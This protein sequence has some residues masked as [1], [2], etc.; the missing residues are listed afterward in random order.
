MNFMQDLSKSISTNGS[1]VKIY[2]DDIEEI[3][4]ILKKENPGGISLIAENKSFEFGEIGLLK[5]EKVEMLQIIA[6]FPNDFD[7]FIV[8]F[9][10]YGVSMDCF[11]N[12]TQMIGLV[13]KIEDYL[14]N[15]NRIFGK[16]AKNQSLMGNTIGLSFGLSL[17]MTAWIYKNNITTTTFLLIDLILVI[18]PL[19][20]I[21]LVTSYKNAIFLKEKK[22]CKNMLKQY[23]VAIFLILA[24]LTLL[25]AIL[26]W[27]FP[28]NP[29]D[30]ISP[31]TEEIKI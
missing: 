14:K 20:C 23:N 28:R 26:A 21:Y 17:L 31:A 30:K 13:K 1:F 22:D 2:L 24:I 19:F 11:K 29:K 15:K 5:K 12:T 4:S 6:Y 8:T 27:Q 25:I 7:K 3:I 18:L 9:D 16:I 10:R